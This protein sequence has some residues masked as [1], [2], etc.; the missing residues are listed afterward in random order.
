MKQVITLFLIAFTVIGYAQTA[1][2]IFNPGYKNIRWLGIDFSH[3]KLI[4][5][6]SQFSGIGELSNRQIRDDYFV[7]WNKLIIAEPDKYD[8][9]GMLRNQ[10][11]LYDIDMIRKVNSLTPL[12]S[13]ESYNPP[14]YTIK[15]IEEF[16][17][18]Y[19]TKNME[20]IGIL[21]LAESLDKSWEQ[22]TFYFVA[23]K[24]KTGEPLFIKKLS[25]EPRGFGMR[26]YWAGS[27][28]N[29]IKEIKKVLYEGWK[30]EVN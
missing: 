20:G 23:L 30:N 6:F 9:K 27:V 7:A 22:G 10:N 15:D 19:D 11:M 8:V 26:N 25:G 3:V 12:D 29:I 18:H 1:K 21:F 2:D 14:N 24:L 4:G 13:M 5:D 17:S 28:Y 16:V